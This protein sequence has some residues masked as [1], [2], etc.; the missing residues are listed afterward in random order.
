MV[1]EI[2]D[3]EAWTT[4]AGFDFEDLTYH[5]AKSGK[6]VRVSFNRPDCRNAFRP[7][8]VDHFIHINIYQYRPIPISLAP[9]A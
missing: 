2:F 9:I 5:I 4:V 8:T 6:T 7:K 1:S 3:V